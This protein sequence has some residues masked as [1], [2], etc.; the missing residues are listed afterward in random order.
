MP[1]WAIDSIKIYI[2]YNRARKSYNK[3]S[4]ELHSVEDTEP[5]IKMGRGIS[6]NELESNVRRCGA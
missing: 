2:I 3:V 5:D 1:L 4:D 6:Q